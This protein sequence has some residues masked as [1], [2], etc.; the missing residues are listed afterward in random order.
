MRH[1]KI[2]ARGYSINAVSRHLD[3]I[4]RWFVRVVAPF[5]PPPKLRRLT[6]ILIL[7]YACVIPTTPG[8]S[9]VL[10]LHGVHR[11]ETGHAR[12]VRSQASPL[13]PR[14][15]LPNLIEGTVPTRSLR[16]YR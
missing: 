13:P 10:E 2:V 1:N 7:A 12:E 6:M 15:Q 16:A 5:S 11:A 8:R 14:I 4:S 9:D 3:A